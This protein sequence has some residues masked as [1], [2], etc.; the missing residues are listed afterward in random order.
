VDFFFLFFLGDYGGGFHKILVEKI[1]GNIRTG[2][3]F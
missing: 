1:K 2:T 3:L